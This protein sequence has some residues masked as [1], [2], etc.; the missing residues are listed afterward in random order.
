VNF[1]HIFF[2]QQKK[3]GRGIK[4]ILIR[5]SHAHNYE[6][7]HGTGNGFHSTGN[8]SHETGNG[9]HGTGN[10]LRNFGGGFSAATCAAAA[11]ILV[12]L[13]LTLLLLSTVNNF[14]VDEDSSVELFA[15]YIIV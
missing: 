14:D 7:C 10:G 15:V 5:R 2:S 13:L 12:L 4:S 8:D 6:I 11:A 9:C 1:R 3:N